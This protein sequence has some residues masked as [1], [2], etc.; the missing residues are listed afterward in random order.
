[1][2]ARR[3][4]PP[5]WPVP[6]PRPAGGGGR[7]VEP[8]ACAHL[9][10]VLLVGDEVDAGLHAGVG[11]LPEHVLL[12]LVDIW[13]ARDSE[14]RPGG[15]PRPASPHPTG[16]PHLRSGPRSCRWPGTA[17]FSCPSSW[18]RGCRWAGSRAYLGKTRKGSPPGSGGSPCPHLP[19]G[20]ACRSQAQPSPALT[21]P[22]VMPPPSRPLTRAGRALQAEVRL[23]EV[24]L[25]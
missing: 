11:T 2:P 22:P 8:A 21:P 3:L 17:S 13:G 18:R 25:V 16:V 14:N 15:A 24:R 6:D 4:L 19:P 7:R 5:L 9:D 20:L 10:G 23:P 1:M 12:Q